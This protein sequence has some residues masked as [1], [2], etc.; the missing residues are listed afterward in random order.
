LFPVSRRPRPSRR[1]LVEP[2]VQEI[3]VSTS[4]EWSGL[5]A[6][7]TA[8]GGDA[9]T[10]IL[11]LA[12]AKDVITFSGGFPAA[13]AF[14]VEALGELTET[15]LADEGRSALQYSPTEGLPS[16][17]RAMA[18]FVEQSQGARPE[19]ERLLVT[20]GG[21]EALQLLSRVLLDPGDLVLV[22]APTYLGAVMAFA[23]F[24][25]EVQ[26]IDMDGDGLRVDDLEAVLAGGARPKL[27]Y[28]IPDHQN[29]TGHSLSTERRRALVELC[30]HYG[31]L[32]IE[33][34]AYRELSFDGSTR[35]SLW[36]LGP[37]VVLQIGTF[38][39]I[40]FP[41]VR[42]GW[43]IGPGEVV[44]VMT[45]AKQNSDQCAGALGQRLLESFLATGQFEA[46]LKH[47]RGIYSER[48]AAMVAALEEHAG[49]GLSFTRP[50]GGFFVWLT[51]PAGVDTEA[52][53]PEASR[54]GV[55]YVPGRPFYVDG[56]GRSEIRLSFSRAS[57]QEIAEGIARLA[58]LLQAGRA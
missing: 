44:S 6:R 22:E 41:G 26:G 21:I 25:A 53:C 16:V 47:A 55:A 15:L 40:F 43:A 5:F 58:P 2:T 35:P 31:V 54:R 18:D 36:S 42:L 52:L 29:P 24:E 12:D 20:S 33:D 11:S 56:R 7:R 1:E 32:C 46:H 4:L 50:S 23:G 38:S 10:A 39:K 17:R 34:V 30:R 3:S 9:L 51:A 19:P 13:Q 37:D 14:P 8:K 57:E 28:V 27:I 45:A 48:G 49:S